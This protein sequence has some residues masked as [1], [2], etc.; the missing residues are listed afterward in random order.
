MSA[1]L[2]SVKSTFQYAKNAATDRKERELYEGLIQIIEAIED[3]DKRAAGLP[4]RA[5]L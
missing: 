5:D 1:N 3:L 4:R 2:G